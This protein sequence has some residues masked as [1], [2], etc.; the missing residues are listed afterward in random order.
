MRGQDDELEKD[1]VQD[2]R[3]API[4]AR[5]TAALE[6]AVKLTLTPQEMAEQDVDALRL[7][8]FSDMEIAG[9]ALVTAHFNFMNRVAQGLGVE[10][11]DA[12]TLESIFPGAKR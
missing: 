1:L 2:W 12:G 8:S 4:S 9:I 11:P 6:Y 10:A 5:T 7:A 3:A